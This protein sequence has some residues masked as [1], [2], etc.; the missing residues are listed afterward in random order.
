MDTRR[1]Y[2]SSKD[3]QEQFPYNETIEVDLKSS[4]NTA[5]SN[6]V[7]AVSLIKASLP[8]TLEAVPRTLSKFDGILK[9]PPD[10]S[11]LTFSFDAGVSVSHIYF[12]DYNKINGADPEDAYMFWTLTTR[13]GEILALMNKKGGASTANGIKV[14][15]VDGLPQQ[16]LICGATT[17]LIYGPQ[18]SVRILRVLGLNEVGNTTITPVIPSP[19]PFSMASALPV[20]YI[21]TSLGVGGFMTGKKGGNVNVLGSILTDL[22][23]QIGGQGTT[24][25]VSSGTVTG[26]TAISRINYVNVGSQGSHKIV[27]DNHFQQVLFNIVD[28]D[29]NKVGTGGQDW[30]MTIDVKT[31]R[32]NPV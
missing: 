6:E 21:T 29:N 27:D 26:V 24:A 10:C 1:L 15:T 8:S 3:T 23:T 28:S 30:T 4:L 7:L 25:Y 17:C 18:T 9:P 2:I 31:V 32:S 16:R 20:V 11:V 12:N 14:Q 22:E 5:K 19:Y 13:L